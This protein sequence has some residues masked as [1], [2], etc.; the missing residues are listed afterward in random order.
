LSALQEPLP[1]PTALAGLMRSIDQVVADVMPLVDDVNDP[2]N[3]IRASASRAKQHMEYLSSGKGGGEDIERCVHQLKI[4]GVSLEKFK[5]Y[6]DKESIHSIVKLAEMLQK[7]WD[8]I[9]R[10]EVRVKQSPAKPIKPEDIKPLD[11][12]ALDQLAY[13]LVSWEAATHYADPKITPGAVAQ[14]DRP[15]AVAYPSQQHS[16]RTTLT[17][18]GH[19]MQ[20]LL[21]SHLFTCAEESRVPPSKPQGCRPRGKDQR[22]LG[23]RS[24]R[25]GFQTELEPTR[26]VDVYEPS[27]QINQ[28]PM[29]FV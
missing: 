10:A 3:K 1:A 22:A 18:E 8:H 4:V 26:V 12:D 7:E 11:Q 15:C 17:A 27:P 21:P 14:Q 23:T 5:S 2:D 24:P 19:K 9:Q 6:V 28:P 16:R 13:Q 20:R 25:T 29:R